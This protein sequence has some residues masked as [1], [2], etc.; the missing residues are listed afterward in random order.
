MEGLIA[1]WFARHTGKMI[2]QYQKAAQDVAA[3]LPSGCHVLEVAPGPGYFTG[4]DP[5]SGALV[6]LFNPRQ[7]RWEDHFALRGAFM[8]GLI[9]IGTGYVLDRHMKEGS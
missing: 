5:D 6:R 4:I 2:G 1:R 3:K 7:D 9:L 8:V